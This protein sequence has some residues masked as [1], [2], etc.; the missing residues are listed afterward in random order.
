MTSNKNKSG[1][2]LL[3]L[4]VCLVLVF[5]ITP[6]RNI[7]QPVAN[8]SAQE[9][10][11]PKSKQQQPIIESRPRNKSVSTVH[12]QTATQPVLEQSRGKLTAYLA[13]RQQ[14]IVGRYA[15]RETDNPADN[16][17][18]VS[19][20]RELQATD[21]VWLNYRLAGVADHSGVACS[22]NDRLAFGGYLVKTDTAIRWQKVQLNAAWLHKGNNRIQFGL[23]AN[24]TYGY[25]VTDLALEV[26][27]NAVAVGELIVNGGRTRYDGKVYVH[28]FVVG[29]N[30][31][32]LTIDGKPVTL[33]DGRFEY[34]DAADTTLTVTARIGK[35]I[36]SRVLR[37]TQT[38][39]PDHVYAL[40]TRVEVEKATFRKN[41]NNSMETDLALLKAPARVMLNTV[42]LSSTTL[43]GIDLPAMDM[44]MTNVT[45]ESRGVRFLPHGQHFRGEGATIALKYDR[46]KIPD[47]YTEND[48]RTY[49]FDTNTNHWV[50][51]ERDTVDKQLCMV[52]SKTTHFTDM[53]NGVIKTPES[54]ETQGFAPTMMNDIKAADPT[55]KIELIAPPTA[56]NMGSANLSYPIEL[57]PARNGMNPN[58]A[59]S[60]NS[61][62]GSGWLGEGWDLQ[63]PTISVDTRWGV[64][65]YDKIRESETYLLNGVPLARTFNVEDGN[66]N[67]V[68]YPDRGV[69]Y[70]RNTTD[71]EFRFYPRNQ[72]DFPLIIRYGTKPESYYWIVTDKRG[73]KY[74]YGHKENSRLTGD[75][76]NIELGIKKDNYK[77]A[78]AEWKLQ[79]M[80]DIHGDSVSYIYDTAADEDGYGNLKPKAIYLS[81]IKTY[82]YKNS[83]GTTEYVNS[84]EITF[85]SSNT[86]KKT[87]KTNNARYGFLVS[88]QRLLDK[89][90]IK[91]AD[92]NGVLQ[93][94]RSYVF[95]YK[96][97]APLLSDLLEF[98]KNI[99]NT[100]TEIAIHNFDYYDNTSNGKNIFAPTP[101][102]ITNP[103]SNIYNNLITGNNNSIEKANG[104]LNNNN[105]VGVG[106]SLYAGVGL[107]LDF[108]SLRNSIGINAG[109]QTNI[110]NG[111]SQLIDINGDGLP[112]YVFF[113][114]NKL[115][116]RSFDFI[117]NKFLNPIEIKDA[118]ASFYLSR[119]NNFTLGLG[120]NGS[121]FGFNIAGRVDWD[122][123][124]TTHTS[125]YFMDVNNDGLVD[126]VNNKKVYFNYLVNG[127]P[128]FTTYSNLT[129]MPMNKE[130]IYNNSEGLSDIIRYD[131]TK[132]IEAEARANTLQDIVRVWQA[133]YSGQIK[134]SG[135]IQLLPP[136][137]NYDQ[138]AYEQ[139]DGVRVAI[140]LMHEE[141]W[142]DT[143]GKNQYTPVSIN[144]IRTVNEGDYIFF[145]VQSGNQLTSNGDF[146]NVLWTPKINYLSTTGNITEVRDICGYS[147]LEYISSEAN[148]V[149]K[150]GYN[151]VRDD[152]TINSLTI[153]LDKATTNGDLTLDVYYSN[154]TQYYEDQYDSENNR[155]INPD[156]VI[157]KL[158]P[159]QFDAA[160]TYSSFT[161]V[162]ISP[163]GISGKKYK[164]FWFK[165]SSTKDEKWNEIKCNIEINY[166]YINQSNQ[167]RSDVQIAGVNYNT[168]YSSYDSIKNSNIIYNDTI[169]TYIAPVPD[170]DY[171]DLPITKDGF[172]NIYNSNADYDNSVGPPVV[173]CKPIIAKYDATTNSLREHPISFL[174]GKIR[175]E[176][177]DGLFIKEV[178]FADLN[179]K[180]RINEIN[181]P[182][183]N[184]K[185]IKMSLCIDDLMY[186]NLIYAIGIYRD[187]TTSINSAEKLQYV[188]MPDKVYQKQEFK[189]DYGPMY[190]GWGHFQYNASYDRYKNPINLD[191]LYIPKDTSNFLFEDMHL[192]PLVPHIET[193]SSW[194]GLSDN[195]KLDGDILTSG[196]LLSNS[197]GLKTFLSKDGP[198]RAPA[199]NEDVNYQIEAP[200]LLS[201]QKNFSY[202]LSLSLER[203]NDVL[204]KLPKKVRNKI[205][206]SLS[207][208]S[209]SGVSTKVVDYI[210][211]NGD[212]FPDYFND[213]KIL[214]S[215]SRGT[216]TDIY[217]EQPQTKEN[218]KT[219]SMSGGVPSPFY[220]S[221]TTNLVTQSSQAAAQIS[222]SSSVTKT[223]AEAIYD[224]IDINGDG[225]PDKIDKSN[226]NESK[227]S[228]NLGYSFSPSFIP[229][230]DLDFT[231]RTSFSYNAGLGIGVDVGAFSAGT[232]VA[233]AGSNIY[234]KLIDM[235]GDGLLDLVYSDKSSGSFW[236]YVFKPNKVFVRLNNGNG[237]DNTPIELG[238]NS[239]EKNISTTNSINTGGG[240]GIPLWG[241]KVVFSGN[242]QLSST[243]S[244][245]IDDIRDMNGD[246]IPDLVSTINDTTGAKLS[247]KTSTIGFTNKLKSVT[248]PLGG[249]FIMDYSRSKPTTDNAGGKW[250]LN[251]VTIDDGVSDDGPNSSIDYDYDGGKYNRREREFDGF[252]RVT[253]LDKEDNAIYRKSIQ[254]YDV[255]NT[256][257]KG[258]LLS[259]AVYDGNNN[260]Y[261]ETTNKY[262]LYSVKTHRSQNCNDCDDAEKAEFGTDPG[263]GKIYNNFT[264][265]LLT[266]NK[267]PDDIIAYTPLKY[268]ETR[269]IKP[270]AQ[271][272][273]KT[274]S[275]YTYWV[276]YH[277]TYNQFGALRSFCYSNN[278]ALNENGGNDYDYKTEIDYYS[279][280]TSQ[281]FVADLPTKYTVKDK[282]G[283]IYRQTKAYYTHKGYPTHL[284]RATQ[285]LNQNGDSA[286]T[287]MQYDKAGN[288]IHKLLPSG[289]AYTYSYDDKYKMYVTQMKDTFGYTYQMPEYDYRFGIPLKT[290]DINGNVMMQT[291]DNRGR[292]ETITGPN[293]YVAGATTQQYT[294]KFEYVPQK[295][296]KNAEDVYTQMPYAITKHYDGTQTGTD[297]DLETVTFVDGFGRAI[298]VKK[299]SVV[300]GQPKMIVSGR[301]KYDAFG[302]V[303]EAYYPVVGEMTNKTV[304][305]ATPDN[306]AP[307]TRT[308]Y[309]VLDRVLTTTLPDNATTTNTYS[310]A[311]GKLLTRVTD[312][313]GKYQDTYTTGDGKTV[314]TVQYKTYTGTTGSDPLSTLFEYDAINQ[315]VKVTD[316]A[317]K[318]TESVY[319]LAG[320]RTQVTHLA[321]GITTFKYDAAGNLTEKLT[322]NLR[323]GGYQPI[324]Y[325]YDFNRLKEINYPLHPE[326]DVKYVYGTKDEAGVAN[327]YRAGRL[328][329]LEDGSG[330][331]EYKYGKQGE[332]TEL[333]RTLVI[334]NQA[335]ATYVTGTTYDS[336]NRLLRMKYPDGE[337]VKYSYNTGGLLTNVKDST[338]NYNYVENILY[339][340]FEQRTYL[341][342]GN[343]AETFYTYNDSNRVL[344]SLSV[345]SSKLAGTPVIMNNSYTYDAVKNITKVVNT[346]SELAAAGTISGAIGGHMEHNYKYD[347]L[348]RL[349]EAH[350]DYNKSNTMKNAHYDLFMGYD[351]MHN[352]VSKRQEINQNGVQFVGGLNAGYNFNYSINADNCQQISNIADSSYRYASGE[353]KK[354]DYK[355]RQYSYDANGNLLSVN[356]GKPISETAF[357][358]TKSRRLLWDEENRLLALNDNGYVSNYF[359]D[360]DG[361]RT[362]KMSFDGEGV[363]VNGALSGARTGTAN[364][365]AYINPYMAVNNG[366]I[367]TKHIYMGSQR[368]TSKVGNFFTAS[369]SPVENTTL[370]AKYVAQT[371][372]IKERFDSLGVKYSGV[373]HSGT[374]ISGTTGTVGKYFYHPDHLGSSSLITDPTGA[375]AQHVEYVPFGETF[376]DERNS[377]W[378]TPYLF[379]AKERDAETGLHYYG[380]R[381]YDSEGVHWLSTDP[382]K[383]KFPN[384]SS[385]VYVE[386]N[387][388]KYIDPDGKE[389]LVH[390]NK[391]YRLIIGSYLTKTDDRIHLFA[392]GNPS[393][394]SPVVNGHKVN[395]TNGKEM[396]KFLSENSD[397]WK[398]RKE[399]EVTTIVLH[400]CR[401][402]QSV[403]GKKSVAEKIANE[404]E[405]VKII[406]PDERDYIGVMGEIGPFK[407]KNQDSN[408]EYTSSDHSKSDI[409]GSWKEF[410]PKQTKEKSTKF[411]YDP[412]LLLFKIP[413]DEKK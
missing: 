329:S 278:G 272:A 108:W 239:I 167:T 19:I 262:Y 17:F 138:S 83:N 376:I 361:E 132:D 307:P 289:M 68:F 189:S 14:A 345:K 131:E 386:N 126:I 204:K 258:N 357:Q 46:T 222:A 28:G 284:T 401:T 344:S 404:M 391:E 164:Y 360:A 113:V 93:L 412:K 124:N 370:Q 121:I 241:F 52:V 343:D 23:P 58:L 339:D 273:T 259:T 123:T 327:G 88:N 225:L 230:F 171:P 247:V 266:D 286:I 312:A 70:E 118:P 16:V 382:L 2:I 144:K 8:N 101:R 172:F 159:L 1:G 184:V 13:S 146:D 269:L 84:A 114:G 290:I 98:V 358:A 296:V 64:P 77:T 271:N 408:G 119:T 381:Y 9:A 313:N 196:R 292:I 53:I 328:K 127:Q 54:P 256:Y 206:I 251:K 409:K 151:V 96:M 201:K 335:V 125:D 10:E 331:Q 205:S 213:G 104:I 395:I 209:S 390:F 214:Y 42:K 73:T 392:H 198:L 61:D 38:V 393:K 397:T 326:N 21:C 336:W 74:Y 233:S 317:A 168:S 356:I 75:V 130:T 274:N 242:L 97:N 276:D 315:L 372:K 322:A 314:K 129:S 66:D 103:N 235:N 25:K 193:K 29:V 22:V 373:Q 211:M 299:E 158:A 363:Y 287:R 279:K 398:N 264:Y 288:I 94:L 355:V 323:N 34:L 238:E 379:N 56:N 244:K 249:V 95:S 304:F 384:V 334:P 374:I 297:K 187:I 4:I 128:T 365:T 181:D 263:Y 15:G 216:Q 186:D 142:A 195:I 240:W 226:P 368:I 182:Q 178:N 407:A 362:V 152:A 3:L 11:K 32:Q 134:I 136:T 199:N 387:P 31:T 350:G 410:G 280:M 26:E 161:P 294:I 148:F 371:A 57:P 86:K 366:G 220:K 403:N 141:I 285:L 346:G 140:Q 298:Q 399:G 92:A 90:E 400:S 333:R 218:V 36:V 33:H 82:T 135:D 6:S 12:L 300:N 351:N 354:I 406:A 237:L 305:D 402:G 268:S 207:A 250:V 150:T 377:T 246:G 243:N 71:N 107:G 367:Y 69:V 234:R 217:S 260:L 5:A 324:K 310:I 24:A 78:I 202:Q 149:S 60:Y 169:S 112:D 18:T 380:A 67:K 76:Q 301:A 309:D 91:S 219:A 347:N 155:V 302:R 340:K 208:G 133:P 308:T 248:N 55:A 228:I 293:E 232:G 388:I 122:L 173:K 116:Y 89:I 369:N 359:Y 203:L 283:A 325:Q 383:E 253:I 85:I 385:Y 120:A 342:Y 353:Q 37:F 30:N 99:D 188:L 109:Y 194:Q 154:S 79:S 349:V 378:Q 160:S 20:D 321:S 318:T 49:Y 145:R 51:L 245:I 190:R 352:V 65:Q 337:V 163:S 338:N 43:R 255:S 63:I 265:N 115:Y 212:G 105:S 405:N 156:F 267:I 396:E 295:I 330:V 102:T 81:Q 231:K 47:G 59:I 185:N 375:I 50:A 137:E 316:A 389:K 197:I 319:D 252:G 277:E 227:V 106:G 291:V 139:A 40:N 254:M 7:L 62:G 162:D 332:V 147:N 270:G 174:S 39:T 44:G 166:Q 223:E 341:K 306:S 45:S 35:R 110:T 191:S 348:Y 311:E 180:I 179:K 303:T 183:Y 364:F 281:Y 275:F 87:K 80:V 257:V 72:T 157:N 282:N 48:I 175:F 41:K 221:A 153:H 177:A 170:P 165:L 413:N 192:V 200:V 229:S 320:R 411:T 143:I 111:I 210:D 261:S 100:S 27:T 394:I 224:F 117:Q 176:T 215:N 236:D